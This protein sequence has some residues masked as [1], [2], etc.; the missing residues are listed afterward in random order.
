MI[1]LQNNDYYVKLDL[2]GGQITRFRGEV[3]EIEY[4]HDGNPEYW[5]YSSPTLFPIIGSSY[6]KKYH[7]NGHT[8]EMENHGILRNA[9][10][11]LKSHIGNTVTLRFESDEETFSKFPYYFAIEIEYTLINNKLIVEYTISNEGVIEMPFNFGLHPAFTCPLTP[12]KQ[13]E[14]YKL[15]FSSPTHL[16]GD[17]PMVNEGL[18]SEIPLTYEAFEQFPTWMYHNVGSAEVGITDGEHGVNVSVV[19]YPVVAVWTNAEA[20]SPFICIEP[21]LGVSR[22]VDKDLRFEDRDAVM[23]LEA[24]KSLTLTYTITVF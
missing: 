5:G 19:G 2:D 6:D 24:N 3:K 7:F 4:I 11:T 17:G 15:T 8:T 18:V 22:K 9:R 21:W 14:D 20:K 10:F 1:V 13:F 12:D 16:K 23:S